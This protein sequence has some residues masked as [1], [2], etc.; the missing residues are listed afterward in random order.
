MNILKQLPRLPEGYQWHHLK[1]QV[2]ANTLVHHHELHDV[3]QPHVE[4]TELSFSELCE[5]FANAKNNSIMPHAAGDFIIFA[6]R[7]FIKQPIVIVKPYIKPKKKRSDDDEYGFQKVYM[8]EEDANL[9]PEDFGIV[10]VFNGL[11]YYAPAMENVIC[12]LSDDLTSVRTHTVDALDR[13]N[14][15]LAKLPQSGCKDSLSKAALHM[16]AAKD[17]LREH[18]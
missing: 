18:M 3:L 15:L 1:C 13:A 14:E 12:E 5:H 9:S 4:K 11:N 10:M 6:C 8:N 2:L 16:R 17:F 7:L